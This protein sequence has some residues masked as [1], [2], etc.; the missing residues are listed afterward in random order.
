MKPLEQR[1]AVYLAK[2]FVSQKFHRRFVTDLAKAL[3]VEA[4]AETDVR[5]AIKAA[6]HGLLGKGY[7]LLE[8]FR[9]EKGVGGRWLAA[10]DRKA[11]PKQDTA[12]GS[13]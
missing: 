1:L 5:K 4:A 10:F 8:A 13:G 6:A 3:P 9:F 7:P 2:K 11:A 12:V